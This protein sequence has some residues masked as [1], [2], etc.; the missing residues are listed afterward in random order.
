VK[1]VCDRVRR[2]I[3][4]VEDPHTKRGL[5]LGHLRSAIRILQD[6]YEKELSE[7]DSLNSVKADPATEVVLSDG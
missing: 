1:E 3:A 6:E 7:F 4:K 5:R 2:L